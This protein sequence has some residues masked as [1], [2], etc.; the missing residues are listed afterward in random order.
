MNDAAEARWLVLI[1]QIPP[2]PD[3]FRVKV[4]RRLQRLGAV[5]IKNSVYV[6]PRSADSLEDFQWLA[7]EIAQEDGDASIC[8]ARFVTGLSDEQIHD[9]FHQARKADYTQLAEET[10][11]VG[12]T[13][14]ASSD[15]DEALRGQAE[16]DLARLKRRFTE[17]SAIDFFNAPG[18]E[19]AAGL[20][21]GLESKLRPAP[22]PE[23]STRPSP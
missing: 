3:Y 14:P 18:R 13:T 12:R 23:T 8:E 4:G 17:V 22:A 9:L 10:R 6:L 16:I 19:A 11:R 20:I 5:A 15:L 2:K 7:R 21:A 1:H